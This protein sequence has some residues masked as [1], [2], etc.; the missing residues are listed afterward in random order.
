LGKALA[1]GDVT[2]DG[3]DDLIVTDNGNAYVI[4]G[5]SLDLQPPTA[6]DVVSDCATTLIDGAIKAACKGDCSSSD[7]GASVA[8]GNLDGKGGGEVIV[9]APGMKVR[10][11]GGAVL[12]YRID[13]GNTATLTDTLF[14]SSA[15]GGDRIGET[16]AAARLDD[17]SVVVAGGA[18]GSKAAVF[19]CSSLVPAGSKGARCE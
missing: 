9:G 14:M 18:G 7:F 4:S 10:K 13:S 12:L 6:P 15:K 1:S 3:K 8:V 11:R 16:V 19:F 2:G 5:A 17:R